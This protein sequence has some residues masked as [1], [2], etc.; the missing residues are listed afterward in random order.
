MV[1]DVDELSGTSFRSDAYTRETETDSWALMGGVGSDAVDTRAQF[2][3]KRF[4]YVR[5]IVTATG[6]AFA[7][8]VT[9]Y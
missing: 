1:V 7:A 2:N 6:S 8:G 9:G 3:F 4:R 5:V